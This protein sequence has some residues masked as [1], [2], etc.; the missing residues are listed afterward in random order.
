MT[1]LS[2]KHIT[3]KIN[4]DSD[5]PISQTQLDML[6]KVVDKVFANLNIDVEFTRHFLD[7]VNDERNRKQITIRELGELFAKEYRRWGNTIKHMP[8]D[9][10]AVMKDLSSAINIP[11]VLNKDKKGKEL[12]AKTVMRKKNFKTPNKELPVEGVNKVVTKENTNAGLHNLAQSAIEYLENLR[13]AHSDNYGMVSSIDN[14]LGPIRSYLRRNNEKGLVDLLMNDDYLT[15]WRKENNVSNKTL[16]TGVVIENISQVKGSEPTPNKRKPNKGGETPHPMRDK[17]VG[18]EI[19]NERWKKN[20]WGG[21]TTDK[22]SFKVDKLQGKNEKYLVRF[23]TGIMAYYKTFDEV[24]SLPELNSFDAAK[25]ADQ[26]MQKTGRIARNGDFEII[27]PVREADDESFVRTFV[28]DRRREGWSVYASRINHGVHGAH[29]FEFE[30]DG[31]EFEII[32]KDNHWELFRDGPTISGRGEEFDRLDAAFQTATDMNEAM[33]EPPLD[34]RTLE[35]DAIAHHHGVDP[36]NIEKQLALG[37]EVELEHTT[38]PAVARE[39]ALDHL[40][41]L[42]DYYD[43][44]S[45]IET[46]TPQSVQAAW[47]NYQIAERI[48]DPREAILRKALQYLDHK[49]QSNQERQSLGGLAFDVAREINLKSVNITAKDLS[50]LYRQWRGNNVVTEGWLEENLYYL[51]EVIITEPKRKNNANKK[52][53]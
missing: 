3:A 7:R 26:I 10:Q 42:P 9:T 40:M 37:I 51:D 8:V 20:I 46:H 47:E 32:G 11:F 17:L 38:D 5:P 22:V 53:R 27:K 12:V 25:K 33:D 23:D 19:L 14:R 13:A 30:R 15:N 18:E 44:L 34:V 45:G 21:E 39:I 48:M 29:R 31:L 49:V 35:V 28:K 43:R 41:E 6:E 24:M 16:S 52:A 4:E 50:D 36:D 1:N 2:K